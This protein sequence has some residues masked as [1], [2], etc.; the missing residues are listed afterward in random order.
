MDHATA[1][2]SML[3]NLDRWRHLPKYQLERRADLFFGLF[4]H[5]I[6]SDRFSR[7]VHQIIIPEFPYS[8][9]KTTKTTVNFDYVLLSEDCSTAY[10]VE[11][12]TDTK[13]IRKEQ[14]DYLK[15]ARKMNFMENIKNLITVYSATKQKGKYRNLFELLEELNF[16]SWDD[17]E[18]KYK[19][20]L[21][22]A[23]SPQIQV[24]YVTPKL[25]E[26]KMSE[27]SEYAEVILFDEIA[28]FLNGR[29]PV[30]TLFADHLRL[31][32]Q[33]TAGELNG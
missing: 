14:E 22:V 17:N 10:I 18:L 31:W 23:S 13:S 6:I 29:G 12:K 24:V 7:K 33:I 21:D 5:D 8:N 11:L 1:I 16:L 4:M 30:E 25:D 28:N 15:L 9:N 32:D 26:E 3:K 20:L 2:E 27:I 19:P